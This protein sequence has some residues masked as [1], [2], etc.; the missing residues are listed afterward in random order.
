MMKKTFRLIPLLL[1]AAVLLSGCAVD[2]FNDGNVVFGGAF[3]LAEDERVDGDLA[4]FGAAAEMEAGSTVTGDIFIMGGNLI[5]AGTIEGDLVIIGGNAELRPSA[6]ILGDVTT[7]GGGFNP[8]G[9]RIEGDRISG[10][11]ITAIPFDMDWVS[12]IQLPDNVL[13]GMNI[14]IRSRVESYFFNSFIL[15]VLAVLVVVMSPAASERIAE[16]LI[17]KPGQSFGLGI[18]TTIVYPLLLVIMIVTICLIPVALIAIL[19]L[20]LAWLVGMVAIGLE[21]GKR[22][23]LA[24]NQEVHP[25]IWAAL[26]TL[27][28][29]LVVNGIGFIPCVG[30]AV[31]YLVGVAGLGAAIITRFGT[32]PAAPPAV[33]PLIDEL[34]P[35]DGGESEK[36]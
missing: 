36:A 25:V 20:V 34:P 35:T 31:Q 3:Y 11:N 12:G 33:V 8:N 7:I 4:I 10:E 32:Q 18:L 2:S 23:F 16:G 30:W 5:G 9:A 1:L 29:A 21:I 27:L 15:A 17:T 6:V 22:I 13:E 19:L 14:S 28:L 26:G 24:L